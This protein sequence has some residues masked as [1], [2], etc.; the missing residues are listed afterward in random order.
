MELIHELITSLVIPSQDPGGKV[1]V[2]Q[3]CIAPAQGWIKLNCDGA[4]DAATGDAGAGVVA[5]DE[6]GAFL[7][8]SLVLQVP[9]QGGP[10]YR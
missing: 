8:A 5:R 1:K 4:L 3:K 10:F 2:K 9:E 7:F 6:Q